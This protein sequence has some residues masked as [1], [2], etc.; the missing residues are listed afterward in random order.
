MYLLTQNRHVHV[1]KIY[2]KVY[3]QC[4]D[5]QLLACIYSKWN[6]FPRIQSCLLFATMVNIP[7]CEGRE[8]GLWLAMHDLGLMVALTWLPEAADALWYKKHYINYRKNWILNINMKH[9]SL[10]KNNI[11]VTYK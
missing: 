9:L 4:N 2:F 1:Y 7:P 8:V 10:L 5:I 11:S 3:L 6:K